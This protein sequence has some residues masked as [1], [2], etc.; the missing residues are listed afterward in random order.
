MPSFVDSGIIWVK[1]IY[2]N[3]VSC[4]ILNVQYML[5][6]VLR[7]VYFVGFDPQM[8]L[9]GRFALKKYDIWGENVSRNSNR[10]KN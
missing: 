1:P 9:I 3:S 8:R 2:C 6:P 5:F 7:R 10:Q 4:D